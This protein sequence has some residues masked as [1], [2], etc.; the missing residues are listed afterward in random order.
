[1][2]LADLLAVLKDP[3]P[4]VPFLQQGTELNEV[5]DEGL[6]KMASLYV[7]LIHHSNKDI[8][9]RWDNS[10][11]DEFARLFQ[12]YGDIKC[13]NVLEWIHKNQVPKNKKVTC[14]RYTVAIRPEKVEPFRMRI[15]A[16]GD[17]LDYFGDVSTDSS[18]MENHQVP[19]EFRSVCPR[20]K[21]LHR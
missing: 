16:G 12:G 9:D 21:I 14:P 1:M 17:H 5:W 3:Q 11:V 7:D 19:L 8:R 10:G 4:A 13:M 20:R 2:I 18:S 15:T 6:N